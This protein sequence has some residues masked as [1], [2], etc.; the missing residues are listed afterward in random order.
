[1][2]GMFARFLSLSAALL[3]AMQPAAGQGPTEYDVKAGFIHNIAKF[4][5]WPA[6][7]AA[8]GVL[9]LCVLG[10]GPVGEAVGDWRGKPV[11]SAVW[12]VVPV[13]AYANLSECQVL[14]INA[15]EAGNLP[16]LL[17]RLA[18]SPIL[19]VGDTEGFGAQGVMVNFYLE[20]NRVRF[21]INL[22][23]TKQAGLAISSQVL[24][25]ARIVNQTGGG[26]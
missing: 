22:A 12:D 18:D 24:K 6:P 4:V 5:D 2:S 26:R 11:G 15:S 9:R 3:L 7:V 10:P 16:R 14:F 23:A 20:R 1:M 25:L 19:T 13:T 17:A 8:K 21:E